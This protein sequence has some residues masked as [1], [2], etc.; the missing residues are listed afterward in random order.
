MIRCRCGVWTDLG[1]MCSKCAA[2]AWIPTLP[3]TLDE[4]EE[5]EDTKVSLEDLEEIEEDE[6]D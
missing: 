2:D 1:L 4:D 6:D 5:Q 3:P